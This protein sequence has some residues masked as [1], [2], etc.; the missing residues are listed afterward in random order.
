M[1]DL[2]LNETLPTIDLGQLIGYKFTVEHAGNLLKA[3]ITEQADDKIYHDKYTGVNDDHL[4]YEE[5]VNMLNRESTEV[6]HLWTLPGY[7]PSKSKNR[8]ETNNGSR[9]AMGYRGENLGTH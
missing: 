4:T 3:K 6:H 9:S 8:C 5:I 2:I 1:K 7:K